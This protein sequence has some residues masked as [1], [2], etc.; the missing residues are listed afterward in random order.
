[1]AICVGLTQDG[2][3]LKTTMAYVVRNLKPIPFDSMGNMLARDGFYTGQYHIFGRKEKAK[4]YPTSHKAKHALQKLLKS[5][6]CHEDF[7][8]EDFVVESL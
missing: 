1:M 2:Y 3:K 7:T 6:L 4:Q 5:Y 8:V